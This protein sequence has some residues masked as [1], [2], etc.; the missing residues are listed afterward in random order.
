MSAPFFVSENWQSDSLSFS[1]KGI[2]ALIQS[3]PANRTVLSPQV[4]P[5]F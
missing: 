1:D 3:T 5:N 4:T 2:S